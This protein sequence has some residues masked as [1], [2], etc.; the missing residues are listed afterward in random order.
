MKIIDLSHYITPTMPVYPGT[1]P[2]SFTTPCTIE[3]VG[4]I[5]KKITLFSHTGTHIDAPSHI[6]NGATT[7]D[8][9]PADN[10]IGKAFLLNLKSIRKPTIDLSD[11]EH[12]QNRIRNSEFIL[13]YTGWSRL[14][15]KETYFQGYPVLSLEAAQWLSNFELKGLGTDMI[16]VDEAGSSEFPIH[17][18]LLARNIIIIEN[19]TNL[20]SLPNINFIFSCFP[21]RIKQADGSPVRAMAIIK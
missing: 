13:L 2:P 12:H 15:G 4:F 1:S 11:L 19:L 7:L 17:R 18:I 6:I 5:E 16:S 3:N 8:Q 14:W 9:L 21:L 20:Q 10:F